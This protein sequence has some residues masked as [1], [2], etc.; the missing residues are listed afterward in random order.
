MAFLLRKT[1]HYSNILCP[2]Y[3][4]WTLLGIKF[5]MTLLWFIFLRLIEVRLFDFKHFIRLLID[6]WI[7]KWQLALLITIPYPVKHQFSFIGPKT[8]T[9]YSPHTWYPNTNAPRYTNQNLG[10]ELNFHSLIQGIIKAYL[11]YGH[12]RKR[13]VIPRPSGYNP[14][15]T[16]TR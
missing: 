16:V 7:A 9:N 1:S 14:S 3:V 11:Y 13:Q 12:I 4:T 5:N 10:N 6:L 2:L 15:V 8:K